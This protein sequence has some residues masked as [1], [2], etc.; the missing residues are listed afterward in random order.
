MKMSKKTRLIALCVALTL[1]LAIAGTLAYLQDVSREVVNTFEKS[2]INVELE[3]TT[4]S[5]YKIIPGKTVAKD[6]KVSGSTEVP[7]YVFVTVKDETEGLVD[8]TI[9]SGLTALPGVPGVYYFEVPAGEFSDVSVLKDDQVAFD[10]ALTVADMGDLDVDAQLTFKAFII[11][12]E[13][14]A[15]AAAA[16][17]GL[18]QLPNASIDEIPSSELPATLQDTITGDEVALDTAIQFAA[19]EDP[20]DIVGKPYENWKADFVLSF[21]KDIADGSKI[22]LFGQYDAY[23]ADWL[24]DDLET[25]GYSTLNAGQEIHIMDAMMAAVGNPGASVTYSDIVNVV[26]EFNCGIAAENPESG[27]VATLHLILTDD[28]GHSNIVDTF[29]Y[30][31]D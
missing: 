1:V 27:L 23:S 11:Q 24:G 30:A 4:G 9:D 21:N 6:P 10:P 14:F 20:A 15:D 28:E 7:A 18:T 29:T 26:R 16:Y 3:E 22:H 5:N 12:K 17:A 25:L 31:F 8:Y 2:D 19:T 13:G